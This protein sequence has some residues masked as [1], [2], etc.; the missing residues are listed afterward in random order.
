MDKPHLIHKKFSLPKGCS[1][2]SFTI[3]EID[4][5]DELDASRILQARGSSAENWQ[6]AAFEENLRISIYAVDG[7]KVEQPYYN[8]NKWSSRTRRYLAEAWNLLN[9]IEDDALAV[10]LGAAEDLSL[11]RD[12]PAAEEL[13]EEEAGLLER[14]KAAAG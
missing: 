10:F 3:R 9:G 6:V 12:L 11:K 5:K 4:G 2:E 1:V 8:M 13:T 14:S 7:N